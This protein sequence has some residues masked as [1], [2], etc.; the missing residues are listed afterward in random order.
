MITL[1]V[2]KCG[3]NAFGTMEQLKYLWSRKL[4]LIRSRLTTHST[5]R[6]TKK[7]GN[8]KNVHGKI[9]NENDGYYLNMI[10][11]FSATIS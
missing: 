6:R 8:L 3:S 7:K 9:E 5:K 11:V 10:N 1:H 2:R 4:L